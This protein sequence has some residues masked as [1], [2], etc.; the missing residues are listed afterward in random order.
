MKFFTRA[1][2]LAVLIVA[3]GFTAE[4]QTPPTISF[5]GLP[6]MTAEIV[7]T[8]SG[9]PISDF[10]L[11]CDKDGNIF[12]NQEFLNPPTLDIGAHITGPGLYGC[13]LEAR[14]AN[15]VVVKSAVMGWE[16]IQTEAGGLS[17]KIRIEPK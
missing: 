7:W 2:I 9:G 17:W 1:C 6:I 3:R 15:Q 13:R 12:I 11:V 4:A 8:W 14:D 10:L 16:I 5:L